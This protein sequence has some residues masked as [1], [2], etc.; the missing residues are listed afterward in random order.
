[1]TISIN[2]EKAFDKIQ[3]PVMIKKKSLRNIGSERKFLNLIFKNLQKSTANIILNGEKLNAFS[4]KTGDKARMSTF[5]TL[6]QHSAGRFSHWNKI[7]KGNK[8]RTSQN[9]RNK[10]VSMY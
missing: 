7:R 6:I 5:T 9:G 8:G 1:M 3:H 10:T 2:E 4:P